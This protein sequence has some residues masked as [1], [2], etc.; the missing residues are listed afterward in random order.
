M[1]LKKGESYEGF[2]LVEE[3]SIKEI[4]GEGRWFRHEQS[5][6][7]VLALQNKDPHK[8]FSVNFMTLPKDNTGHLL[9][10]R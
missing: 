2:Q 9:Y 5:G 10:V 1:Q 3:R 4:E 6:I 7:Q 8:V